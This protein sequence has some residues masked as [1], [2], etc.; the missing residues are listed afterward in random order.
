MTILKESCLCRL[1]LFLW[2]A[3][4]DSGLH[5]LAVRAG[6][7][8]NEQIDGSAVLRLL[9]REGAAARSWPDSAAC[10]ALSWLVNL[11]GRLLRNFCLLLEG[12]FADSFFARLAFR[13]G[14]ETAVAQSWLIL[15]LWIIPYEYWNNAYTLAAF[16]LL[17]L[18]LLAGHMGRG[19]RPLD[20]SRIGFFPALFFGAVLLG[21]AFSLTRNASMRFLVYHVSAALCVVVTVSALRSMEELK[22]LAAAASGCVAVSSLYAV[23]QRIQGI[24]VS[25]SNVDL[26]L[27]LNAGMPGRVYSFFDNSNTFAEVLLLLLPLTLALAL[28]ARRPL[29]R[30]LAAGVF[31]LGVTALGMT[32]SRASWIGFA[33]AMVVMV[34]LW[35]PRLLPV[36]LVLCILAV[37]FLPGS[38]WNR[39][40]TI[41]DTSDS[42][43]ASRFPLYKT[44]LD[45]ILRRPLSGVGLGTAAVQ[46]YVKLYNLYHDHAPFV[47]IHNIYLQVWAELGIL[48]ITGFVGSVLWGIKR[49]AHAVRHCGDSAARAVTCG[50]CAALCGAMVCGLADHL[51]NYPR[52]MCIFWFVFAVALGGVKLCGETAEP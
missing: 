14:D 40:L 34:F 36:F 5:R 20:I 41:G 37:P 28:C 52:V 46:R 16:V 32:Y 9:C 25:A 51:W 47:H 22:R 31:C 17:L 39:I 26:D 18:L 38:I 13:L 27:A 2:A 29:G 33:C 49:A 4:Q 12:T 10:R 43:T 3:Y 1:L 23:F 42:S 7:W 6:A 8:C 11:P 19:D 48:G 50:A 15:L 44:G 30:L 45:V 21:V 24:E 35:K